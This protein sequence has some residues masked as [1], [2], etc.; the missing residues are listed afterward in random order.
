MSSPI[1]WRNVEASDLRGAA[2]MLHLAGNS[3]NSGFDK[4]NQVLQ[5]EQATAEAN[6][7]Q[8]KE[9][10]TQAFLNSI[11]QYRTPEEYQ[12][13]LAS[14]ALST[15]QYGAQIDQ[16]AARSA[17]DGRLAI[18]QDRAVKAGQ[19]EDQQKAREAKP[20]VDQ[21]SMMALS[22][23]KDVRAS[24]KAALAPYMEAG[25]LPNG[26][27]LAGKIRMADRQN[28]EWGQADTRFAND[29]E[30]HKAEMALQPGRLQAQQDAHLN[31]VV[32]RRL[33]EAQV[34]ATRAE[35]GTAGDR[36]FQKQNTEQLKRFRE[37][38]A[39]GKDFSTDP[40]KNIS[41]IGDMIQEKLGK[42]SPG[43]AQ[44]ISRF[45]AE[46]PYI[47]VKDTQGNTE[48][49]PLN[50]AV[51]SRAIQ[52]VDSGKKDSWIPGM[53]N[54][55]YGDEYVAQVQNK[56]QELMH[57]GAKEGSAESMLNSYATLRQ[58]TANS[59]YG[60]AP[61][62]VLQESAAPPLASRTEST[63]P[64]GAAALE[65]AAAEAKKPESSGQPS[66]DPQT[67]LAQVAAKDPKVKTFWVNG[68]RYKYQSVTDSDNQVTGNAWVRDGNTNG[69]FSSGVSS[70]R[71][72]H[73]YTGEDSGADV[74]TSATTTAAFKESLKNSGGV[75][76]APAD[77]PKV[78]A[79][80]AGNV[81]QAKVPVVASH[82]VAYTDAGV[83]TPVDAPAPSKAAIKSL[84]STPDVV[85]TY[86]GSI[87]KGEATKVRV[88]VGD[89]DTFKFQPS[90]PN[91][92]VPNAV[93]NVCRFDVIDAPEE[94]HPAYGKRGQPS[95]EEAAAYLRNLMDN[96]EVSIKVFG[97][98]KR[99]DGGPARNICQVEIEGKAVDLEMVKAGFAHVFDGYI[100][101][102]NP[103]YKDL[104]QAESFA[105][106]NKLGMFKGGY[107][108]PG[109]VFRAEERKLGR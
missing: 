72:K 2:S 46:N 26:A 75:T 5:N 17:L 67:I 15:N 59:L 7:K 9:N 63:S 21:L 19:F 18:L 51:V 16:A 86:A 24:A 49:L 108:Q 11:N 50:A 81:G 35:A 79:P 74:K 22:E 90:D 104:K 54:T 71:T 44:K 84:S 40:A 28:T 3:I 66:V 6:W 109:W 31:A 32:S 89:G 69:I 105:Q 10:N 102:N 91:Q 53:S 88:T 36:A 62:Q 85:S 45:V 96:K 48:Q 70:A 95:G 97:Q 83:P 107:A 52:L 82:G 56:I 30:K 4:L 47:P 99:K 34:E 58:L 78:S 100:N 33:H 39:Y 87:P 73:G 25:M 37:D 13:A 80:M 60:R 8:G 101:K 20:I 41:I 38:N 94:A 103:R 42:V 23:D 1:T 92:K 14:G 61:Q 93:G 57:S 65:K 29:T 43:A 76:N 77:Q 106:T 68:E 98:D 27:E 64:P 55:G 12:A